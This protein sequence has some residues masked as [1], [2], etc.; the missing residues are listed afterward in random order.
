MLFNINIAS[1]LTMIMTMTMSI[2]MFMMTIMS[3]G[4]SMTQSVDNSIEP[5]ML[6]GCIFYMA[7]SAV[8]FLYSITAC[9]YIN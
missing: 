2:T 7:G 3:R 1:G 8:G 5:T 6:I 4:M 9:K